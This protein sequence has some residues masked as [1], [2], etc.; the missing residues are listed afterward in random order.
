[1]NQKVPLGRFIEPQ[2]IASAVS[3]LAGTNSRSITGVVL[4]IDGGQSL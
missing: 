2:E 3:F 1:L 4:P